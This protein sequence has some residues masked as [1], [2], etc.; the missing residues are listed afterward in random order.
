M[1][2]ADALVVKTQSGEYRKVTLSSIRPPR[3]TQPAKDGKE[4]GK[5]DEPAKVKNKMEGG[6]S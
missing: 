2:N 1:V 5:D 4:H 6:A 3:L